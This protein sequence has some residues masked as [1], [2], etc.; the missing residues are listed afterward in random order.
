MRLDERKFIAW[1]RAKPPTEIVGENRDCH[2]CP[3][4][5]FYSETAGNDIVIF[6]RYGGGDYMGD[7][8][9][10]ARRLPAWAKD[11]IFEVDGDSDGKISA[12][13]ALQALGVPLTSDQQ[14]G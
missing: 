11:F 8:G 10:G 4:A 3:I 9:G 14:K 6:D 7:R 13:R 12:R 2:S 5:T 1:L